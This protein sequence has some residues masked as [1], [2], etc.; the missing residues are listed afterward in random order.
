MISPKTVICKD[1]ILL[2]SHQGSKRVKSKQKRRHFFHYVICFRTEQDSGRHALL[3]V[4]TTLLELSV[5]RYMSP[6]GR[7]ALLYSLFS[8]KYF[9]PSLFTG[10]S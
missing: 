9:S 1:V 3:Q 10:K 2:L 7:H 6:G 8:L 4:Y 5:L